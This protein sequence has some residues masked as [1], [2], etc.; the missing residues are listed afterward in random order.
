MVILLVSCREIDDKRLLMKISVD[1]R[2]ETLLRSYRVLYKYTVRHNNETKWEF[3][4]KRM[5]TGCNADR[6]LSVPKDQIQQL[7][8]MFLQFFL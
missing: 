5:T 3:V 7:T 2:K 1:I 4:P 8:G 6:S